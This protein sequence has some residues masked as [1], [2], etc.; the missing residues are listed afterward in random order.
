[1]AERPDD[2]LSKR[3]ASVRVIRWDPLGWAVAIDHSNGKHRAYAV[4]PREVAEAE[5]QRIRF[6]GT[7]LTREEVEQHLRDS[8]L[9]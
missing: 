3:P 5:A 4:G 2:T 8:G 9:T 7:P 6:G 1:M